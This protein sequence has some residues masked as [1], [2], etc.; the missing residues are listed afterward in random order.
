MGRQSGDRDNVPFDFRY[1][2]LLLRV[3]GDLEVELDE[4]AHG[5]RVRQGCH[6]PRLSALYKPQKKWRLAEQADPR[7]GTY[8]LL[9]M[10]SDKGPR[11]L[12]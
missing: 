8:A 4:Y 5:V 11:G 12:A 9:G 1:H 3:A 2:D 7:R 10:L 6:L